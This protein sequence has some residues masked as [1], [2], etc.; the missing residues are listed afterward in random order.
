MSSLQKIY[1]LTVIILANFICPFCSTAQN[2]ITNIDKK[3]ILIGEQITYSL[4]IILP[5]AEYSVTLAVPDSIAHFE[6]LDKQQNDTTDRNGTYSW[7]QKIVFTSFDSGSYPFPAFVYRIN[8]LSTTSQPLSTDT[9]T[10]NVGYMPLDAGGKPRD[11]TS[12]IDVPFF[13]ILWVIGAVA[14]LVFLIIIWLLYRYLN[15][16]YKNPYATNAK[17]AYQLAMLAL[18][19]VK[20]AN[21]TQSLTIKDYHTALATILKNYVGSISN[22]NILHNT[23]NQILQKLQA[24]QLKAETAAQTVEA[25]QTGDAVKFAKYQA[26]LLENEAALQYLQNTITEI[27]QSQQIKP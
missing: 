27:H 11:I 13:N 2:I 15:K 24:H 5:N 21:K 23:S 16:K 6:I 18:Q 1:F 25:L 3:D 4:K 10:V 17:T 26:S 7:Q 12:V 20:E 8:H 22:Q 14:L 9:F 19:N